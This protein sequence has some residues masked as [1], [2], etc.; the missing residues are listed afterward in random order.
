M[1]GD[2]A[3]TWRLPAAAEDAGDSDGAGPGRAAG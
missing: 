3:T 2:G 1:D